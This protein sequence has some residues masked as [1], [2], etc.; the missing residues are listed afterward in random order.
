MARAAIEVRVAQEQ[1][2]NKMTREQEPGGSKMLVVT[3]I[4]G[5]TVLRDAFSSTVD[6]AMIDVFAHP[7]SAPEG[8][9]IALAA[10]DDLS[11]NKQ[12]YGG[13]R[14]A[15]VFRAKVNTLC[16]GPEKRAPSSRSR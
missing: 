9:Q 2:A 8:R 1:A 7:L 13:P 16:R 10:G 15:T 14:Q 5:P 6:A 12:I 4:L 11:I 3:S